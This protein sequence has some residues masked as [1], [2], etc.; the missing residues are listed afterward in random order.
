MPVSGID[1]V[2]LFLKHD[3]GNA[4]LAPNL[5]HH[6]SCVNSKA[7]QIRRGQLR[8]SRRCNKEKKNYYYYYYMSFKSQLMIEQGEVQVMGQM[9]IID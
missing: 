4:Y 5:P 8:L 3:G 9:V 1:H 2:I 6:T 7:L